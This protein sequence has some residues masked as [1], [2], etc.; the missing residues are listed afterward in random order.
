MLDMREDQEDEQEEELDMEVDMDD[1]SG[2]DDP[3][4]ICM[5]GSDEEFG[6]LYDSDNG[7]K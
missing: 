7:T 1:P 6:D 5:E 2:M 4:E 3:H